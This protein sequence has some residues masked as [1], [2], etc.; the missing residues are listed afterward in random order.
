MKGRVFSD[1]IIGQLNASISRMSRLLF[2]E[3]QII[4]GE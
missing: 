2:L 1:E 4:I 3:N